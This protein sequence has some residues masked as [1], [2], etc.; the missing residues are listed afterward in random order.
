MSMKLSMIRVAPLA[1]DEA[2]TPGETYRVGKTYVPTD[3]DEQGAETSYSTRTAPS[4]PGTYTITVGGKTDTL[5]VESTD[6]PDS[7]GLID[8]QD[9]TEVNPDT[10]ETVEFDPSTSDKPA[11][12]ANNKDTLN[13]KAALALAGLAAL[14]L[15]QR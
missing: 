11:Q 6:D 7:P 3:P 12:D 8:K 1:G 9:G 4:K 13:R 2:I 15:S 14:Y 5:V 10:G